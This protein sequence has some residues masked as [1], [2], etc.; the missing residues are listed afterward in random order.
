LDSNEKDWKAIWKIK[1]PEKMNIHLWRFVHDC[2]PSGVQLRK[3]Q[4]PADDTC[5]LCGRSESIEHAMLFCQFARVVWREIKEH[6]P[7]KLNRKYFE[8]CKSWLFDFLCRSSDLQTTVLAVVF[9]H[10]WV[11]RNEARN[12]D[13]KPNPSRTSV[14]ILAYVDLIKEHLYK[15]NLKHMCV[16]NPTTTI[17]TP[18]LQGTV[19]INIDAAIFEAAECVGVGVVMRDH[20]GTCLVACRLRGSNNLSM[21]RLWLFGGRLS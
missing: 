15:P 17:W 19:L 4:I 1:A 11:A 9:W 10:I 14:K 21:R 12:L 20:R 13:V 5:I 6:V 2:L 16:S 3:R 7:L 8:S 18:P